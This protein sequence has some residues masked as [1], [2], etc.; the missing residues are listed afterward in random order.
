MCGAVILRELA[1]I[2]QRVGPCMESK[3]YGIHIEN[4]G[5]QVCAVLGF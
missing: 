3:M 2:R 5:F 1:E 4:E